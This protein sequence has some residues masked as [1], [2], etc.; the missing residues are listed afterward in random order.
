MADYDQVL[1]TA[2]TITSG[3]AIHSG[4]RVLL[5]HAPT[6][7]FTTTVSG[8][9]LD[10]GKLPCLCYVD[11]NGHRMKHVERSGVLFPSENFDQGLLKQQCAES[12]SNVVTSR[13][14]SAQKSGAVWKV[15][16]NYVAK[17]ERCLPAPCS[18]FHVREGKDFNDAVVAFYDAR[19]GHHKPL[20]WYEWDGSDLTATLDYTIK[21]RDL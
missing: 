13:F 20:T 18:G 8:W 12:I 9:D 14:K 11:C 3:V 16:A 15:P 10:K 5:A 1:G 7:D 2:Q 21:S 19:V 17:L 4:L 6:M